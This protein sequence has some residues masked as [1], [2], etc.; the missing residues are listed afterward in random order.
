MRRRSWILLGACMTARMVFLATLPRTLAA[1]GD[2]GRDEWQRPAEVLSALQV[3]EGAVVADV[4]AGRGYFTVK[5][6]EAVGATGRVF[7][8]DIDRG[9]LA[10]LTDRVERDGLTSV[11]VVQGA[12]DDPNL[13]ADSLDAVL[14]VDAYHEMTESDAMLDS[15]LRSLKPGG[16]LVLLDFQP[17]D[18]DAP[19]ANQTAAHTIARAIAEADLIEHGFEIIFREDSF[20]NARGTR[21]RRDVEWMVVAR[22]PHVVR[23]RMDSQVRPVM[24]PQLMELPRISGVSGEEARRIQG[25]LRKNHVKR[26]PAGFEPRLVAGADVSAP[27]GRGTGHAAIVVLD[28]TTLEVADRAVASGPV[29][30][31]YIPGLLSFRELPL[32]LEAWRQLDRLPDAVIFDGH[33]YAHPRRFGLA[34]HGGLLLD[35]PA[36]GCAKSIL[37][38]GHGELGPKAGSTAEIRHLGEVVG[39]AVRTRS[40]VRPV[41]VSVSHRMDL[42]TA[43]ELVLS[44]SPR[45]RVPEPVRAA[46]RLVRRLSTEADD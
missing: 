14:V 38:G 19:R 1:Q 36:V 46:D 18:P 4:G 10:R 6:A 23:P 39:M 8:V 24:L 45:Y 42:E 29:E 31:P 12:V 33:G 3:R 35:L 17:S 15:M 16:R 21:A 37:I 30:F 5:L 34:C 32:L 11:Q 9:V 44:V 22:R 27:P 25:R 20:T 28:M 43:V 7:A 13:P 40:R 26:P 41:Y 2:L